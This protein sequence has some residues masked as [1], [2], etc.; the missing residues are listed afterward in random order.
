MQQL[1]N[2]TEDRREALLIDEARRIAAGES[3]KQPSADHLMAL[4]TAL[5]GRPPEPPRQAWDGRGLP[6]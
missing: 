2:I 6:F 1:A 5:D 4:L 3:R